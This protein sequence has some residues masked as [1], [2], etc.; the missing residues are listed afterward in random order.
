MQLDLEAKLISGEERLKYLKIDDLRN[1]KIQRILVKNQ[2]KIKII[3][4]YRNTRTNCYSQVLRKLTDKKPNL[5]KIS[6]PDKITGI[7][8]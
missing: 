5:N 2:A 3:P 1:K 7:W 6:S 8:I 4:S